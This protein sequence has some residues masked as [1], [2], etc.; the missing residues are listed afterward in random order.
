MSCQQKNLIAPACA[1]ALLLGTTVR[2]QAQDLKTERP[3]MAAAEPVVLDW[4]KVPWPALDYTRQAL[5]G[6]G[7]LY[8][9]AS[10]QT[11]KFN[12]T[13]VFPTGVYSLEQSQRP[14]LGAFVDLLIEGGTGK[15][16]FE[17]LQQYTQENGLALDASIS[18]KG[19]VSVTLEGLSKDFDPA[20]QL[21]SEVLRQPAFRAEAFAT[22][23]RNKKAEFERLMDAKSM[24]EQ[25]RLL[26]PALTQVLLGKDHYFATFLE[27]NQPSTIEAIKLEQVRELHG[28][29]VTRRNVLAMLSGQVS[30]KQ[31]SG[32][33]RLI[34]QLPAG[35]PSDAVIKWLPGRGTLPAHNKAVVTVIRKADMPQTNVVGRVLMTSAGTLNALEEAHLALARDVFSSSAGAVGEDRFSGALRKRSGLSYSANARFDVDAV[36]PNT[37]VSSWNM[38]FQTPADKTAD[39]LKLAW[40]TWQDFRTKGIT[41]DEFRKTRIVLMNKMLASESPVLQKAALLLAVLAD[42]KIPSTTPDED[43]L[44]RLEAVKNHEAVNDL[45]R[46]LTAPE[47]TLM[48]FGLIGSATD[49]TLATIAKLPFVE[50]VDVVTFDELKKRY[51]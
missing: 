18:G 49:E 46:R 24:G 28:R 37:N 5:N 50:R 35:Q 40:E 21:L 3:A 12:L 7:G 11:K 15:R 4:R 10:N 13:I 42:G 16:S 45:L 27:R 25:M 47:S 30:A 23:K 6:G 20:L 17:A 43:T 31:T 36:Q 32:V 19:T 1:L 38:V 2:A 8:V 34:E 44:A 14:T 29:I 48:A 33:A 9:V 41:A 51:L 22:W 26:E 39:G